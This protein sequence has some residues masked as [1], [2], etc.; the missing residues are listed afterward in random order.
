MFLQS[1]GVAK[2]KPRR[3][4]VLLPAPKKKVVQE[5][6]PPLSVPQVEEKKKVRFPR[7][8]LKVHTISVPLAHANSDGKEKIVFGA[9][10]QCLGRHDPVNRI[11]NPLPAGTGGHLS[12]VGVQGGG[13][14]NAG[15]SQ[16]SHSPKPVPKV[17]M[18]NRRSH[19]DQ[20]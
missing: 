9:G 17:A 20:V 19:L 15:Q 4:R 11:V 8:L 2:V 10:D 16:V 5:S 14:L 18:P 13:L 6:F 12:G 1:A 7:L 3:L